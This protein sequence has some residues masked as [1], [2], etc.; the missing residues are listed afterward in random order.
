MFLSK[1]TATLLIPLF[2]CCYN[3]NTNYKERDVNENIVSNVN[4]TQAGRRNV[5]ILG[6]WITPPNILICDNIITEAKVTS[7]LNFWQRI[8]YSFGTI[9]NGDILEC[10]NT[11]YNE[12]KIML[13]MNIDMED[14]LAV[15]QIFRNS[16]TAENLYAIISIYPVTVN[17]R[18]ILEHEIGHALGWQHSNQ[19][20]HVMYPEYESLGHHSQYVRYNDYLH[21][22]GIMLEN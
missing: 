15:T 14:N 6:F 9:T 7:A 1:Y 22:R 12:I 10:L 5:N 3:N 8:G 18:L 16:L 21:R 4:F 11:E 2:I 17:N 20:G 19:R 13:P